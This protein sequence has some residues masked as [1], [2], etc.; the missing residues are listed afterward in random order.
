MNH[1]IKRRNAHI[2]FEGLVHKI[3]T[4]ETH[5]RNGVKTYWFR[6]HCIADGEKWIITEHAKVTRHA[7]TCLECI[8]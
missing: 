2:F 6:T 5:W 4:L 3:K 1:Y 8:A 7:V